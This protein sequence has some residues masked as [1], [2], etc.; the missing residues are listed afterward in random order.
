MEL[1]MEFAKSI[2]NADM[3]TRAYCFM[4]CMWNIVKNSGK[5][6]GVVFTFATLDSLKNFVTKTGSQK[7]LH[8]QVKPFSTLE[9]MQNASEDLVYQLVKHDSE[10]NWIMFQIDCGDGVK[11]SFTR[12]C[13]NTNN[14]WNPVC[15]FCDM[16]AGELKRC[17]K[18]HLATY[19]S[20]QCQK[21]HWQQHKEMCGRSLE[22]VF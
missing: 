2:P 21:Q 6:M 8:V 14:P 7:N 11:C 12:T 13:F 16:C 19:C 10:L 4:P 15:L 20:R 5:R 9:Q 22:Q 18:C 1:M 17:A 3:I